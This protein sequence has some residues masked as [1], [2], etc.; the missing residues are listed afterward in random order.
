MMFIRICI[1]KTAAHH[2]L[3]GGLFLLLCLSAKAQSPVLMP[4]PAEMHQKELPFPLRNGLSISLNGLATDRL[5]KESSRF[6]QRLSE[7]TG[8]WMKTWVVD[9]VHQD[10]AAAIHI[11][12]NERADVQL[13]MDESYQLEVRGSGIQLSAKTDIGAIRGLETLLQLVTPSSRGYY[14]PG[15]S[16][17]DRPRYAWRGLLLSQPYH[18]MSLAAVERLLDQ[19][20]LVKLNVLHYYISDD[21]AFT[22]ESKAYPALHEKASNGQYLTQAQLKEMIA[23]ADQRGIRIIPEIDLPGHSTAILTVFPELASVKRDNVLQDHWG[24][25][26]P[27]IDPTLDRTYQVLDTL[28]TEVASLFPDHYFHIGGDENNGKD[29]A[30]NDSIQRFMKRN[31]LNSTV[32]LQNYFNEHVRAILK[33]SN[34]QVVGWDEV[35]MRAIPADSAKAYFE[36]GQYDKL[37][38]TGVPKDLVIQ[39]WRGMEAL[40]A[41]AKNGYKS[42]LSKGYY[43]DL[44]QSTSYHY[45][46]DPSP[47]MNT[48][49]VPDSEADFDR[50]ESTIMQEIK[51]GK[52]KFSPA[53]ESLIMGGE[54]TMWTEHVTEET[55]DGRVWPRTAAIAERLWSPATVRDVKDMYRRLDVISLHLEWVGSGHERNRWMMMRR[56]ADRS[57]VDA[58]MRVVNL[59]EPVKGYKRNAN[60]ALTKF[61][62]YTEIADV[63]IADPLAL[64][65]FSDLIDSC[66]RNSSTRWRTL[67]DAM[68]KD[69]NKDFY[70]IQR[71]AADHPRLDPLLHHAGQLDVLSSMV[72][73]GNALRFKG[74]HPTAKWKKKA[75]GMLKAASPAYGSCELG[76]VAPLQRWLKSL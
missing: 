39:S 21:Q 37:I 34:K 50:F 33:R 1:S 74:V 41:S 7:H 67:L 60:D 55:L 69:W 59:I 66:I 14:I 56:L 30:R 65:Q 25:F 8:I 22:L 52:L 12:V 62:P 29:W 11:R 18:F 36:S 61:Y 47:A 49:I 27:S 70:Q 35:L 10:P 3:V 15:I 13:G 6:L 57:D 44:M 24:V 5:C 20:A 53:E 31:G 68:A 19:M 28:L 71:M 58:A 51:S 38:Y 45:L 16:I 32:A 40:I 48:E 64:R 72:A 9:P 23:Y 17:L 76:V 42:I 63:A 75:E 4:M 46:N 54:A 43:I 73:E 2:L 26:D